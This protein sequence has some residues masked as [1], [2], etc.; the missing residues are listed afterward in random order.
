MGWRGIPILTALGVIGVARILYDPMPAAAPAAAIN[1]DFDGATDLSRVDFSSWLGPTLAPTT[2]PT[3]MPITDQTHDG[4]ESI[5]SMADTS[6]NAPLM[7]F[8]NSAVQ[9]IQWGDAVTQ[10]TGGIITAPDPFAQPAIDSDTASIDSMVNSA[11]DFSGETSLASRNKSSQITPA[12][13]LSED[14]TSANEP[15]YSIV[16]Y[17]FPANTPLPQTITSLPPVSVPEPYLLLPTF[18]SVGIGRSR[19]V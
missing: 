11:M 9:K 8:R 18:I 14:I 3:T 2:A 6:T 1:T 4:S 12:A 5:D 15:A 10:S 16:G 17:D 7:Y 13:P 19:K